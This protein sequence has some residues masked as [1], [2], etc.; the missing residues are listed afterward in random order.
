MAG[1]GVGPS[2]VALDANHPAASELI[3]ATGLH[4]A[5]PAVDVVIAGLGQRSINK[6]LPCPQ[7]ADV[8][9]DVAAGPG[10]YLDRDD[11]RRL[12]RRRRVDRPPQ[13]GR[14]GGGRDQC[15]KCDACEERLLHSVPLVDEPSYVRMHAIDDHSL[16]CDNWYYSY[17]T[18]NA[19]DRRVLT[20]SG[21]TNF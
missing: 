15:S 10:P 13:V 7:T 16:G 6:L 5:Q 18:I 21:A 2:I 14:D 8:A 4:A 17:C 12:G 19:G 20:L 11:H 9:A 3:I 1:L